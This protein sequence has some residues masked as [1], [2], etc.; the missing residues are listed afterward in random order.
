MKLMT[1]SCSLVC[2][3]ARAC[4]NE[5]EREGLTHNGVDNL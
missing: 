3:L 2:S 4:K 1:N 5:Y